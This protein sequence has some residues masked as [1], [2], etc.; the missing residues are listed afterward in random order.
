M[1]EAVLLLVGAVGSGSLLFVLAPFLL[2]EVRRIRAFDARLATLRRE[3]VAIAA[4]RNRRDRRRLV[5][6]TLGAFGLSLSRIAS[7]LVPIG[8]AEREKLAGTLRH[9]G[10]GAQDALAVFLS[11][12][13]FSALVLAAFTGL[14]AALSDTIGEHGALVVLAALGGLVIGSVVPEYG[15]R[16]LMARR[17]GRMAAT[18]PDALDL[19]MMCLDSGLTFERSL[20]A[21]ADQLAPI[22]RSLANELRL[23]E[24]ELR[25]ASDRRAVLE[26]YSRLAAVNGL[27]D[28]ATSLMQ[29]DR[30]GTPLS[31]SLRNIAAGERLQRTTRI[32]AQSERLPV[33]M[34]LPTLLLVVPGTMILVAGPAFLTALKALSTLGG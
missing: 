31:R 10:F 8:A 21:T 14:M 19:M 9:A 6:P 22:E 30:Y 28:L 27:R 26:E 13:L 12:K 25:L 2:R 11:V 16:T 17:L 29:S 24:A 23:L 3:A 4:P 34:T 1:T 15:L 5:S 20:T 7:V 18:L 33:L 32:T